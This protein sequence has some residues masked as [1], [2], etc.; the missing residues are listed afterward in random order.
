MVYMPLEVYAGQGKF[1]ETQK[2]SISGKI[3]FSSY[4]GES[5]QIWVMNLNS[6]KFFQ[7]THTAQEVRYPAWSPDGRRIAYTNNEG[8]IWVMEIGERPQKLTNLPKNCSHPA[9]SP[10]GSKIVFV[11]YTFK[12]RI[13]DSDIWIADLRQNKVWKL[14]NQEGTQK[15]PAWS[16]DGSTIVYTTG[17]PGIRNKIIEEL[18][19]VNSDGTN[20]RPL[21]SNNSSNIQP[22]WSPDGE[23]IAFASD[24]SGNMEIWVVDKNGRNLKQLTH[25]RYYDADPSWSP[26]GSM[27][28]FV[29]TRGGKMDIWIMDSDGG[30]PGQLSGLSVLQ[31]E[32]KEPDWAR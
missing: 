1:R 7:L 24:M 20:P 21:V 17:Y 25:N 32:S 27:I 3:A 10:D 22:D 31:A 11:C 12:N 16:P 18:W 15:Y 23:R 5:W 19:L 14:I 4:D 6:N 30:N 29:S 26:D 28:T 13:E 9:W 8:E 2:K